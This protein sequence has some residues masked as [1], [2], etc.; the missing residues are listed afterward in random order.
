M[1]S[2]WKPSNSLRRNSKT[3]I[4]AASALGAASFVTKGKKDMPRYIDADKLLEQTAEWEH[5]AQEQC[6]M[7]VNG[8]ANEWSK[9][10]TILQE[11]NAFKMDVVNAPTIDAVEVVRCKDCK[12]SDD[13]CGSLRCNIVAK[14]FVSKNWFCASGERKVK[15]NGENTDAAGV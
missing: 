14:N 11:R 3:G 9:W 4:E 7:L 15:S 8:N 5:R 2:K 1:K 6:K 10:F 12:Y 13:W